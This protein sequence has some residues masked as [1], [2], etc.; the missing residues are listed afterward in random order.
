[1]RVLLLGCSGFV[2][3]ELVPYLLQLGHEL[4]LLSRGAQPPGLPRDSR[5]RLLR[6]DPADPATWSQ[7]GLQQ[8][9][10]AAEGVVNLVGEP[11]AEKRWSPAHCQLLRDSRVRT[12]SL[13]VAAMAALRQPPGVL[14]NGSAVGFY[15]TSEQASFDEASPAGDDLL[16]RLCVD[17]EAA[18]LGAASPTRVVILRLGIVLAADGGALGRMLPVFR[19]GLGGPVGSGRQWLSWVHRTDVCRLIATALEDSSYRGVYNAVA[20]Q[21]ARMGELSQSLGRV[22]GRPSLLPVP[23]PLL[24]VLLG[25]GAKV[26]LEGQRV[27]SQRLEEQGFS[28]QYPELLPALVAATSPGPR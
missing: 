20:P 1:M 5:L 22:L 23:G 8:A 21:P 2:G 24:Q 25:D 18:A 11:I 3:R 9:L 26:V 10:A 16:A 15:G 12:T 7:E 19:L 17:W 6:G 4:T 27:R 13:L 28:F 14:V